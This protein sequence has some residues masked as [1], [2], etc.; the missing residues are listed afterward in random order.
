MQCLPARCIDTARGVGAAFCAG[1]GADCPTENAIPFDCAPYACSAAFGSC[2]ESCR[3]T[4]DCAPG[5]VCGDCACVVPD[6]EGAGDEGCGCRAAGSRTASGWPLL[7]LGATALLRP[8][9]RR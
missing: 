5:H 3:N 7:L 9:R 6:A 4:Q 8:R 1:A 2:F